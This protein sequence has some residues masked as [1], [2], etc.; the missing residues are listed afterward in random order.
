MNY[1]HLINILNILFQHAF[2]VSSPKSYNVYFELSAI[3]IEKCLMDWLIV[4][5]SKRFLC[6]SLSLL[7]TDSKYTQIN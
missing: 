7:I 2:Q 4:Y 1:S 3:L 5:F 6:K